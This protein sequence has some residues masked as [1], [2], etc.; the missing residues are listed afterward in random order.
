MTPN[1]TKLLCLD[2]WKEITFDDLYKY[3]SFT[4]RH[5]SR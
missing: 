4:N 5:H 2:R 1:I 3:F